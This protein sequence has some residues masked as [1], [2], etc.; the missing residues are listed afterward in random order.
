MK[1]QRVEGIGPMSNAQLTSLT[2][3]FVRVELRQ[4]AALGWICIAAGVLVMAALPVLGELVIIFGFL[5]LVGL[6]QTLI[7]DQ[8]GFE[9]SYML[10]RKRH[11]WGDVR[12]FSVIT[13]TKFFIPINR[14]VGFDMANPKV[15][16]LAWLTRL[17][18]G[19][20][21][22]LPQHLGVKAQDLALAMEFRRQFAASG[23]SSFVPA[24][25][26]PASSARPAVPATSNWADKLGGSGATIPAY[27]T[28]PATPFGQ[29][30][31]ANSGLAPSGG[32]F[33]KRTNAFPSTKQKQWP[34]Y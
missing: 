32:G 1:A 17:G 22:Y 7:I 19:A 15:A 6:R 21:R 20:E 26:L 23:A 10:G 25:Q 9:Y 16:A 4:T 5:S 27:A 2:D 29:R 18:A 31:Y 24:G 33:G 14:F 13:M 12:E 8:E 28:Q 3:P 34:D 30:G 11:R